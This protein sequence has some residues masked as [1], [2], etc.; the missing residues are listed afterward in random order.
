MEKA[1]CSRCQREFEVQDGDYAEF[2]PGCS[3]RIAE[4]QQG[5]QFFMQSQKVR[6]DRQGNKIFN[7]ILNSGRSKA[8][9]IALSCIAVIAGIS[10]IGYGGYKGIKYTQKHIRQW[11]IDRKIKNFHAHETKNFRRCQGEIIEDIERISKLLKKT[12]EEVKDGRRGGYIILCRAMK[13]IDH[14]HA[15]RY[16]TAM[17][18]LKK[19]PGEICVKHFKQAEHLKKTDEAIIIMLNHVRQFEKTRAH[20]TSECST[21]CRYVSCGVYQEELE[22]LSGLINLVDASGKL[23]KLYATGDG[24]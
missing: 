20:N 24:E 18:S 8:E 11:N 13:K 9:L 4:K 22:L 15:E 5:R 7:K 14:D 17:N 16:C 1:I 3:A 21:L 19:C 10:I 12:Y 23:M 6:E 2:C